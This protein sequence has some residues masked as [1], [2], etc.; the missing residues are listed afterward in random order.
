[1]TI[2]SGHHVNL[3]GNQ[4]I[5]A[6]LHPVSSDPSAPA[7]SQIW[8]R[9]DTDRFRIRCNG[10][11][12]D[13]AF[14]SE[15]NASGVLGTTWDAQSVVI[16]VTDNV[17]VA[18]VIGEQQ[19]LG[20]VTGGNITALTANNLIS[21]LLDAD[22]AASGLDA[23]LLDGL[24]GS[25]YVTQTEFDA[26][27]Q[28]VDW[29][30]SVRV[31]TTAN[32]TLANEQ[33]VDAIA[34]VAGDRVLVKNQ[35]ATDENG[36]YICVDLGAWTRATDASI[37][38]ELEGAVV[39]VEEGTVNADTSWLQIEDDITLETDPVTWVQYA[40]TYTAGAGL[41]LT[42]S[43]F[44]IDTG[45]IT[46][47]MLASTLTKKYAA[48]IGDNA[49]NPITVTH[50]LGTLDDIVEVYEIANGETVLI[51]PDRIS[52]SAFTLT[53]GVIPTTNQYR[54]VVMG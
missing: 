23:D 16:A 35:T 20:R 43:Q 49:T 5:N 17:P 36:I 50:N 27:V 11:T 53:F 18:Q 29:K 25:D 38:V 37:A 46:D 19:V 42:G 3:D 47:A 52:T 2:K 34:V 40:R 4:L 28:G 54:V 15:I 7:D 44:F 22:G 33:T 1:M 30:N 45:D 14:L 6:L 13:I 51:A 12:Q 26:A 39:Q 21:I 41:T 8:Y 48:D 32:I 9:T 24:Q 31:A 10:V